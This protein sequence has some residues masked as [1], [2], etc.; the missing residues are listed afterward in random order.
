MLVGLIGH[1]TFHI[2]SFHG[3]LFLLSILCALFGAI[4]SRQEGIF[5]SNSKT[6]IKVLCCISFSRGGLSI[7]RLHQV[8]M[9]I[10]LSPHI[11]CTISYCY[12]IW[13]RRHLYL[14]ACAITRKVKLHS[15]YINL[16]YVLALLCV[17]IEYNT[18][19][20]FKIG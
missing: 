8:H 19:A 6:M 9:S 15:F 3:S 11:L 4:W 16:S 12:T 18:N 1:N 5:T 20:S 2:D 14:T 10:G 17:Q 13:S 7:G